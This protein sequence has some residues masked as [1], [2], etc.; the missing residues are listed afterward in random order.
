[1]VKVK[2]VD[3]VKINAVVSKD[4]ISSDLTH[5]NSAKA[6]AL[7]DMSILEKNWPWTKRYIYTHTHTH[8]HTHTPTHTRARI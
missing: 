4:C 2:D 6:Y 3:L 7:K 5:E 1:M 8:T